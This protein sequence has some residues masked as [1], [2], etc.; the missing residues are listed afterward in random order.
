MGKH[1]DIK[2]LVSSFRKWEDWQAFQSP[3][4]K[5][6]LKPLFIAKRQTAIKPECGGFSSEK[7]M[8]TL[9]SFVLKEQ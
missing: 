1:K 2:A 9:T 6:Q 3:V 7:T 4:P 5:L 8:R